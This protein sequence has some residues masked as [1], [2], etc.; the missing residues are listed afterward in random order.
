MDLLGSYDSSSKEDGQLYLQP[1]LRLYQE[2]S[3]VVE[4]TMFSWCWELASQ[5]SLGLLAWGV[6]RAV[7]S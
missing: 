3:V 4:I 6:I 7:L 5:V 1:S 2:K